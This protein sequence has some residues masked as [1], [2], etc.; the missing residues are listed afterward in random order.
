MTDATQPIHVK[1]GE[2]LD[3]VKSVEA[4]TRRA[5][6]GGA[7]TAR[8]DLCDERAVVAMLA[9]IERQFGHLDVLVLNAL[10]GWS[11]AQTPVMPC[12][13]IVMPRSG[14]FVVPSL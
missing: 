14:W 3:A 4:D 1:G 11:A 5:A 8:A 2:P 6:G 10:E 12:G 7:S 9:E 13:S